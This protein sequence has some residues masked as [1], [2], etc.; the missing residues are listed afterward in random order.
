MQLPFRAQPVSCFRF[1]IPI[2]MGLACFDD[3]EAEEAYFDC[4]EEEEMQGF[5]EMEPPD[6]PA[7]EPAAA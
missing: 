1:D 2:A 6:E 4:E 3:P 7:P 5:A